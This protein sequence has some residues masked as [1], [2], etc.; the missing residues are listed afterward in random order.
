MVE[1]VP[2]SK[3]KPLIKLPPHMAR[4]IDREPASAEECENRQPQLTLST[5]ASDLFHATGDLILR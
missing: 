3:L 1:I 4:V 5:T 2:L